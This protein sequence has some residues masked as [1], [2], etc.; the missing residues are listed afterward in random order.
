MV[1]CRMKKPLSAS[2][3]VEILAM[4]PETVREILR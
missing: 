3:T 2:E 4:H 1:K